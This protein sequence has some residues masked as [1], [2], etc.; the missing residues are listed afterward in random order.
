[1]FEIKTRILINASVE[2]V[3][4][5]LTN[6][7]NYSIWNQFLRK[8]EG[9][10]TESK[11]LNINLVAPDNEVMNFTPT[12][13][14]VKKNQ[15]L[16]WVGIFGFSWIFRGEHYFI[17]EEINKHQ[18]QLIHGEKFTG[19]L[20]LIFKKKRGKI[21]QEGFEMMNRNLSDYVVSKNI[22]S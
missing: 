13:I 22:M 20:A 4:S 12:C 16:R 18:T 9:E 17:L 21:T 15:E 5:C 11:K 1:M 6:T 7:R 14:T 8:I 2:A 10:F 3:W 19:I